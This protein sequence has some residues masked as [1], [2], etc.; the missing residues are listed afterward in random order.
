MDATAYPKSEDEFCTATRWGM[1]ARASGIAGFRVPD[2]TLCQ[3]P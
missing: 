2:E 1:V 3:V